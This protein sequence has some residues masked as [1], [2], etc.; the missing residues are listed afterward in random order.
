MKKSL[1]F[2]GFIVMVCLVA[3]WPNTAR[4]QGG[5]ES[6]TGD[7][8]KKAVPQDFYLEGNRIP[9]ENRNAV[10]LKTARGM[11][12]VL[13]LLDTAGYS[14]QIQQKYTGMVITETRFLV[15][16]IALAVGSYGF[17][18]ERPAG[19]SKADAPFKVYN[20]AGEKVGE[21]AAKQDDS[22][23]QP[24]PLAVSTPKTG[25]AKLYLGKYALEI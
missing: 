9:V 7:A 4:A 24:K 25:P 20:Q 2:V 22:V 14:S 13:G 11:R 3:V 10:L 5:L 6:V 1:M 23:Q 18:L 17:G 19:N 15:C 16:G 21:C 12:V 8:F